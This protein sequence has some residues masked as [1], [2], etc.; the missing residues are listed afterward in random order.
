MN[1]ANATS[2]L[3]GK[4]L[5]KAEDSQTITGQKTFQTGAG[6]V[7]FAVSAGNDVL[8]PNLN[9]D[10][11]D[12]QEGS[13][14]TNADHLDAGTIPTARMP[15][16]L[17]AL[18]A[19]NLVNIP[20]ANLTG[21]IPAASLPGLAPVVQVVTST[22]TVNDL[23]VN[24]DTTVLRCENASALVLSGL[25]G[26]A[27]GRCLLV[28][29]VTAAQTLKFTHEDA[30]STAANRFLCES[31]NGQILGAGG[32][33]LC[34]YDARS[35]RWRV[36]LL[37]PGAW[38][39]FTPTLTNITLGSGTLTAR[40]QQR[41]RNVWYQFF[42]VW[43][44]GTSASGTQT[45]SAPITPAI[46]AGDQMGAGYALDSGTASFPLQFVLGGSGNITVLSFTVSGSN[47][48]RAFATGTV[49][50]TWTTSDELRGSVVY[51][52]D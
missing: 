11:L 23:A 43:G 19:E 32:S 34:V 31:T 40:Y 24:D 10:L 8:V 41:G 12:G 4:T 38:I 35:T 22:G 44:V 14:Y 21:P 36:H 28:T 7:P 49:P 50:F 27:D 26:G 25:T 46:G 9:A 2:D 29:N 30:G 16:P 39:T 47:V 20:A 13:Y 52:V 1:I 18:S 33:A 17:P 5:L 51:R 3:D 45:L 42:L 48:I 15:D 6:N 37:N